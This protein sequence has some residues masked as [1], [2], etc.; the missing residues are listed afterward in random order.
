MLLNRC[1]WLLS[2]NISVIVTDWLVLNGYHLH[3][4][5]FCQV[6][7]QCVYWP[8]Y[9]WGCRTVFPL[10]QCGESDW[11]KD[12]NSS[13]KRGWGRPT[14]I[15][16]YWPWVRYV[17]NSV[18]DCSQYLALASINVPPPTTAWPSECTATT[19]AHLNR[20]SATFFFCLYFIGLI[21]QWLPGKTP[22]TVLQSAFAWNYTPV[23]F[24]L[25]I[26]GVHSKKCMK[27][28]TQLFGKL[29]WATYLKTETNYPL[30]ITHYLKHFY[31]I[32]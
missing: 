8:I 5:I 11:F 16:V 26:T 12:L 24:H 18:L 10:F 25:G 17:W 9:G 6:F 3:P 23:C 20:F 7:C 19:Q 4:W 1:H 15:E 31:C 28:S 14:W 21:V 22:D 29:H 13:G 2:A 27:I 32:I 30:H